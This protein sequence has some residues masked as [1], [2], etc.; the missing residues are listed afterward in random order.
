MVGSR[1][2]ICADSPVAASTHVTFTFLVILN[3]KILLLLETLPVSWQLC[4]RVTWFDH[5]LFWMLL[6]LSVFCLCLKV[7][8]IFYLYSLIIF[9]SLCSQPD[10]HVS[11]SRCYSSFFDQWISI[12]QC[13]NE[14]RRNFYVILFGDRRRKNVWTSN[15]D[16]RHIDW[17][18]IWIS[19][20]LQFLNR[21]FFQT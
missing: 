20:V 19:F 18:S 10:L 15:N 9:V 17:Q 12:F 2:V 5:R 3:F 4:H 8:L 7:F 14:A 6:P 11:C 21:F 13:L 1:V 16:W